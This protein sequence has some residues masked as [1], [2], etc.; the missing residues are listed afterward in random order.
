MDR[1]N[2]ITIEQ[3]GY[4]YLEQFRTYAKKNQ[5]DIEQSALL[6]YLANNKVYLGLNSQQIIGCLIIDSTGQQ[7]IWG[8]LERVAYDQVVS[9]SAVSL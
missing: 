2:K 4:Q 8:E 1:D 6:T 5:V 7:V 9:S 3:I